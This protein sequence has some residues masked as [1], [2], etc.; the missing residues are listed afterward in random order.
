MVTAV[1]ILSG[2]QSRRMGQDKARL[3]LEG[4]PLLQWQ[5]LRLQRAGFQ[6]LHDIADNYPGFR[7]PLAG[8]EA[9]LSAHPEV[10]RW[11]VLPV[12]M[13]SLSTSALHDLL[14]AQS[15][16]SAVAC[17]HNQPFPLLIQQ[18]QQVLAL[19]QQWLADPNGRR[20]VKALIDQLG[21]V[22]LA[23]PPDKQQFNNINT[24]EQWRQFKEVEFT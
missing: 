22:S 8:I 9:A 18:P 23:E 7:G 3:V 5:K 15:A 16:D 20:S 17:Y 10:S 2:G 13:P 11:L 14:N 19:L 21:G 6:V 24:P 1:L 4:M 12:D